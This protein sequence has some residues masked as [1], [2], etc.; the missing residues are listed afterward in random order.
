MKPTKYQ[1]RNQPGLFFWVEPV[2]F[3]FMVVCQADGFPATEAFDDWFSNQSDAEAMAK[4][5]AETNPGLG[6][7]T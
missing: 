2:D 4:E 6:D 7:S 1:A 5:L 3:A